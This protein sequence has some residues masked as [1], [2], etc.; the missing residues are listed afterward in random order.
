VEDAD[1]TPTGDGDDR[2]FPCLVGKTLLGTELA[3]PA[4]FP[5]ARTLAVIA[6]RQWQQGCV[7]RWIGEAVDAGV[8]GTPRGAPQPMDT[9]VVEL[10]VLSTRW[11]PARRFIDGGMTSGIGDPD[12]LAR[13]ATVYTDVGAFQRALGIPGSDLVH[14]LVVT[15]D[16]EIVARAHG[17]PTADSWAPLRAALV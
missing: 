8:P 4:D 3:L 14:A 1:V 15:R 9:A 13:T 2:R 5:A 11:R 16:G 7:D 6:F 12:V 10:P 17:E